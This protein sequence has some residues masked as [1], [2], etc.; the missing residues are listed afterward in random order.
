MNVFMVV[1]ALG[2]TV[3]ANPVATTD[4]VG[5]KLYGRCAI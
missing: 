5:E 3:G 1:A 2:L 4:L